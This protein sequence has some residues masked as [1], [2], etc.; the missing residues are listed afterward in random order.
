L[1]LKTV[2]FIG[3][4]TPNFKIYVLQILVPKEKVKLI[5]EEAH[6]SF[7]GGHF[8]VNRPLD[9]TRK[10]FYWATCK[11]DVENWCRTCTICV[12]ICVGPIERGKSELQ[13]YNAG[14]LKDFRWTFLVHYQFLLREIDIC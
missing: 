5:L 13:I 8:G 14:L 4:G 10:R 6:D 3:N 11:Q 7:L 9:R 2:Y 12:A 1:L